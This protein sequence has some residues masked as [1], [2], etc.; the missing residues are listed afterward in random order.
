MLNIHDL[1]PKPGTGRGRTLNGTEALSLTLLEAGILL[2]NHEQYTLS[3]HNLTIS[4]SFL[5][6]GSNLHFDTFY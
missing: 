6:G 4:T 3:T 5:D 2:V 1:N